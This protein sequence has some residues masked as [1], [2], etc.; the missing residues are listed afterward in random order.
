MCLIGVA[1]DAN[2]RYSFMLAANRDESFERTALPAKWWRPSACA[3]TR[4]LSGRDVRAGGTWLGIN[5][6]GQFAALSNIRL[7]TSK[8]AVEKSGSQMEPSRGDLPVMALSEPR[9]ALQ[10]HLHTNHQAYKVFNML[11]G[12]LSAQGAVDLQFHSSLVPWQTLPAGVHVVSNASLNTP[13]PKSEGLRQA[14]SAVQGR[15]A[16]ARV[17]A[18]L[19]AALQDQTLPAD[20]CLPDTGVGLL[21]ERLLAPTFIRM[22][23]YGTRVSTIV[24]QERHS[25]KVRFV[26]I[27]WNTVAA[28]P[29][30]EQRRLYEF[31]PLAV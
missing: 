26:E 27:T 28:Q 11:T 7:P 4:I 23:G 17:E 15:A 3:K 8:E 22:P 18:D 2:E 10:Q 20:E 5:Q 6:Y 24:T 29:E 30:E 16:L 19:L 25:G 12:S 1:V 21:R 31:V 13:W 14:L 9:L